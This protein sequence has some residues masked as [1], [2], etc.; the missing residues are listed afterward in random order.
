MN[1]ET[2]KIL[3]MLETGK[4]DAE[5]AERLLSAIDSA[6]DAKIGERN[7]KRNR[8]LRVRVFEND[9][10]TPKVKVNLPLGLMKILM[11]FGAK[12]SGKIPQSVQDKLQE[13][14]VNIDFDSITSDKLEEIF[15]SLS[16]EGPLKLVEVDDDNE[17]VEVYF[18]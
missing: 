16:E 8:W 17:R 4:I 6:D 15:S 14:G 10:E 9:M 3:E 7:G 11:K 2:R 13:K 5:Q 12:F 18:E 1:A